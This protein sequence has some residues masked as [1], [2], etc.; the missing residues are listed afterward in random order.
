MI[1]GK[2]LTLDSNINKWML[3]EIKTCKG[4]RLMKKIFQWIIHNSCVKSYRI[5]LIQAAHVKK[6]FI[7]SSQVQTLC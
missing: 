7:S 4:Q 2:I 1:F 3:G 6:D 5:F